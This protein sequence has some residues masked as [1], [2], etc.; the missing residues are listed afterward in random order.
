MPLL[1]QIIN[2]NS[3]IYIWKIEESIDVLLSQVILK[4]KSLNRLN[5]MKSESH[6]K[7][8]LA[9]RM[10]LQHI[11]LTDHDLFYSETGKPLLTTGQNISITHAFDFS[12][13]MIS[14]NCC[15]IDIE[16]MKEKI[17]KIGPRFCDEPHLNVKH[18]SLEM[19]IQKYTIAWGVKEAVFKIKNEVGISFPK[20]IHLKPFE[21]DD[22]NSVEVILC[23]NGQKET[24]FANYQAIENYMLVWI[25]HSI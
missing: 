14:E 12:V 18:S 1:H 21:I 24:F 2:E 15:G 19:A 20:H 4:E 22:K 5:H 25:E 9:V 7:G 6:Q 16:K 13:I 23:F 11:N 10:L 3:I 8:F 17:V